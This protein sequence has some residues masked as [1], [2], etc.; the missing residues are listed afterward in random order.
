MQGLVLKKL[1]S[2]YLPGQRTQRVAQGDVLGVAGART[3]PVGQREC[4][5]ERSNEQ[6][7][8]DVERRR[9]ERRG[10][11]AEGV[12]PYQQGIVQGGDDHVELRG[13]ETFSRREVVTD[14]GLGA[15]LPVLQRG[16]EEV[17]EVPGAAGSSLPRWRLRVVATSARFPPG[18]P[19]SMLV[20]SGFRGDAS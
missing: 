20:T 12:S 3:G 8:V 1:D 10:L 7:A 15:G 13:G 6:Q 2:A 17:P 18:A 19:G 14:K 5:Q 16:D 4:E 9:A 11:D